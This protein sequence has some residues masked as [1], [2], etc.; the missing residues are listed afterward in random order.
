MRLGV[1][2]A[3]HGPL[4][5]ALTCGAAGHRF[6]E[7]L[8]EECSCPGSLSGGLWWA[9]LWSPIR[10]RGRWR[11]WGLPWYSLAGH[12][13]SSARSRSALPSG[14]RLIRRHHPR[15]PPLHVTENHNAIF[16]NCRRVFFRWLDS[17]LRRLVINYCNAVCS[18]HASA[19]VLNSTDWASRLYRNRWFPFQHHWTLYWFSAWNK[20]QQKPQPTDCL[21]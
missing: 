11:A 20:T 5:S 9:R 2:A 10:K 6:W 17:L 7:V 18:R 13:W 8:T 3:R 12:S 4:V 19:A 14:R 15:P 16:K 21:F 1:A